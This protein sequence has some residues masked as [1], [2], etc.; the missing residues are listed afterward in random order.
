MVE[1]PLVKG[2]ITYIHSTYCQE[3][4]SLLEECRL[5]RVS[6]MREF[7]VLALIVTHTPRFIYQYLW[8]GW[9]YYDL[10]G[11]I[12]STSRY[13]SYACW[14]LLYHLYIS[15]DIKQC[16]LVQV[17]VLFIYS[18]CR[19]VVDFTAKHVSTS[20]QLWLKIFYF[21]DGEILWA[22]SYGRCGRG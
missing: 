12:T 9:V 17:G 21:A 5:K 8:T 10:P 4:V 15:I 16:I 18:D 14:P 3:F 1:A 20:W 13:G 19:P 6:F 11:E 7:T 22:V 2:S